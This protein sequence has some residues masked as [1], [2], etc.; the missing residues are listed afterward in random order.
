MTPRA[1][2]RGIAAHRAARELRLPPGEFELAVQLG[3]IRPVPDGEGRPHRVLAV[4]VERLRA[5]DGFPEALRERLR[6]VGAVEA[7]ALLGIAPVRF[8]RLARL[9]LLPPLTFRVAGSGALRW[10]YHPS[11]LRAVEHGDPRLL[12]DPSPGEPPEA[13]AVVDR[14]PRAW[15]ERRVRWLAC[16][17]AGPWARAAAWAA[18]LTDELLARTVPRPGERARVLALRPRLTSSRP[19]SAATA[20]TLRALCRATDAEEIRGLRQGVEAGVQEARRAGGPCPARRHPRGVGAPA[21]RAEADGARCGGVRPGRVVRTGRPVP[22]RSGGP[23]A[24]WAPHRLAEGA[25]G[26]S[27]GARGTAAPG[28]PGSPRRQRRRSPRADDEL[29]VGQPAS[30]DGEG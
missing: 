9:G 10:L 16:Q 7:A 28:S 19:R 20:A 8:T 14:R 29:A 2:P 27:A 12:W 15:R 13:A 4:D 21:A 11:E 17:A 1:V 23:V 6:V 3:E 30:R 22:A 24:P 5:A 25:G 26:V 18:P